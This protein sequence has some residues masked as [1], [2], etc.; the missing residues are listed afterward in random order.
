MVEH[1][2]LSDKPRPLHVGPRVYGHTVWGV[3]DE[4]VVTG[5]QIWARP[6]DRNAG[7]VA[8]VGFTLLGFLKGVGGK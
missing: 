1:T 7:L 2:T 8:G 5:P 3:L 6:L 4:D